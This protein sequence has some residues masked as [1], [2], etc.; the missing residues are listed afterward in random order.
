MNSVRQIHHYY[1][2]TEYW[3]YNFVVL[4][5][6]LILIVGLCHSHLDNKHSY[7]VNRQSFLITSICHA[8]FCLFFRPTSKDPEI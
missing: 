6:I 3:V 8:I 2:T 7:I 4:M 5:G 1:F